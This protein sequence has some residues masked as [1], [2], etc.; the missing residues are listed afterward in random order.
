MLVELRPTPPQSYNTA[1]NLCLCQGWEGQL[2]PLGIKLLFTVVCALSCLSVVGKKEAG[3]WTGRVLGD[4][5][6]SYAGTK[7]RIRI[8]A[9]SLAVRGA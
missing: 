6:G 2:Q 9:R 3:G 1:K 7:V 4:T 5:P 8:H